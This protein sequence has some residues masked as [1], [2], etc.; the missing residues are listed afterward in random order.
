MSG[1]TSTKRKPK[2]P[3]EKVLMNAF[4]LS[5]LHRKPVETCFYLDSLRGQIRV[6]RDEDGEQVIYKSEEEYSSGISDIRVDKESGTYLVFTQ[7]S[8]HVLDMEHIKFEE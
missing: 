1:T 4:K 6:A 5:L 3:T 2:Y 8:L 7:N